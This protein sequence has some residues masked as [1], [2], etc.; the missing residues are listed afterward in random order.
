MRGKFC[1][2]S[3]LA[4]LITLGIASGVAAQEISQKVQ[5]QSS[6]LHVRLMGRTAITNPI[7][8]K[9]EAPMPREFTTTGQQSQLVKMHHLAHRWGR[10][11]AQ[12]A[13]QQ[14]APPSVTPLPVISADKGFRGFAALT[15]AEQ[16]S[17]AGFDLEPPDQGMCTDG[18]VV[19]ETVNVAASVYDSTSH[20]VLSGPVYL[21]DFFGVAATDFTSDPTSFFDLYAFDTTN[22]GFIGTCPC[23]ADQPLIGADDNGFYISTNAFGAQ[24]FGG[25]QIYALSKFALVLGIAPFGVHITPLP[26]GGGLPLPFSLQP[27]ASPDGHGSPENGG[28]EYFVSSY[29][30]A[31]QANSKVSV[32]AMTHTDTLNVASGIPGFTT[33]AVNTETYVLPIPASQRVGPIPLG[34]SLGF[35]EGKLDPDDQRMQQVVYADGNLWATVDT[36]VQ[37]GDDTLDGVLYLVIKPSWKNGTLQASVTKQGYVATEDNYLL[38]PAIAV[39]D[40]GAG[41]I[42]FTL[43]GPA[44]FPSAAYIP[45]S[46]RGV[47]NGIR[48]AGAGAAPD[49]GFTEYP[50]ASNGVGRWGDYSAAV[51]VVDDSVWMAT[52]YISTKK[53]DQFTNW[54]TFIGMLPLADID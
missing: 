20:K 28:T 10:V 17:V 35:P 16:A 39:T 53:R 4:T 25:A 50:P 22:D 40:N 21:N 30:I 38:Y 15:G 11:L 5:V 26:S 8:S 37:V 29:N 24:F 23:F 12:K 49:D 36:A 27:A 41:A 19:L 51:A 33:L 14:I 43:T 31:S 46:F 18:S 6:Q 47:A 1:N 32:W 7:G 54:S 42:V 45:I 52:E 2:I 44:Y 48:L 3:V 34:K 9:A 13:L